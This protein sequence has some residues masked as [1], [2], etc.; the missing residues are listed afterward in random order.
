MG[1]LLRRPPPAVQESCARPEPE[2][3]L[4]VRVGAAGGP[5]L[6]MGAVNHCLKHP[7][8]R[9]TPVCLLAVLGAPRSGKTLLLDGLLRGLP[10]LAR[11]GSAGLG[12]S[13]GSGLDA[14]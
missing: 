10:G 6:R 13:G 3:L 5:R 12:G 9:D 7:L 1:R 11:V 4:L 2:P 14:P 8:A